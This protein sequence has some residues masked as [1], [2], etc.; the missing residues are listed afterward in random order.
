MNG[1]VFWLDYSQKDIWR[2]WVSKLPYEKM[3][4]YYNPEYVRLYE[5]DESA[6]SCYVYAKKDDIYVYPFIKKSIPKLAGYFDICTAYGYGGPISNSSDSVFLNEAYQCFYEESV[7]KN[8]V[9][10]LIKFHPLLRN[11]EFLMQ[12]FKGNI[13]RMCSTVYVEIDIDEKQRWEGI[14]THANRKNINKARRNNLEIKIGQDDKS[15]EAFRFLY[16]KTMRTNNAGKI[17]FFSPDYFRHIQKNLADN[18]V[19]VSCMYN[20]EII[21]VL[22]VLLGAVYAH[23]HLIGTAKEFMTLGVNNLLHH[24]LILWCKKKGYEKL[25]IGG[26]RSDNDEDSLL[27]FKKNFSDKISDFYVGESVLNHQ[28]YNQLCDRWRIE[29]PGKEISNRLLKYRF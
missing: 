22:L 29:N 1:Q 23:C 28:A 4:I 8:I 19:L 13:M 11:H 18:Y 3:D 17:Y 27:G 26:G 16:A 25:H 20:G 12:N 5:E 6:A 15:W 7:K 21:S 24:E 9:A 14:Y 2:E 10:E